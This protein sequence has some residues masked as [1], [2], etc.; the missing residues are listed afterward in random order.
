MYSEN[1]S[2][3]DDANEGNS[4]LPMRPIHSILPDTSIHGHDLDNS[5]RQSDRARGW[6]SPA[7]SNLHLLNDQTPSS[8]LPDHGEPTS[9]PTYKFALARTSLNGPRPRPDSESAHGHRNSNAQVSW[10]AARLMATSGDSGDNP[11]VSRSTTLSSSR[12]EP[13]RKTTIVPRV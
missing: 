9:P 12:L 2:P 3:T 10:E 13:V 6:V 7:P 4:V 1:R 5:H 11:S 8:S